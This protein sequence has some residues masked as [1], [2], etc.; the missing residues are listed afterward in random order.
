M[1]AAAGGS[2]RVSPRIWGRL[3]ICSKLHAKRDQS[4]ITTDTHLK[5]PSLRG[6]F[7]VPRRESSENGP[8]PK[9]YVGFLYGQLLDKIRAARVDKPAISHTFRWRT[10][11]VGVEFVNT[12]KQPLSVGCP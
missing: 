8:H 10:P 2:G 9:W 12:N 1:R 6:S 5:S 4:A 11:K 7:A 3:T